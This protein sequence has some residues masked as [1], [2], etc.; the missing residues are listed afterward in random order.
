[1]DYLLDT[2]IMLWWLSAPNKISEKARNIIMDRQNAI[3]V[4]TASFWEM[5]IKRS[6]GKLQFPLNVIEILSSSGVSLLPILPNEALSV[7]DLALLHQDPFDRMLI[8]QAKLNNLVLI[9][10]DP[11]IQQYPIDTVE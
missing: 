2:H 9:T 3:F 1:M 4:S 6:I 7:S 11:Q 10:R 5:A 8:M